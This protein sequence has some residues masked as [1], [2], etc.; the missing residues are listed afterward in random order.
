MKLF[1]KINSKR[2]ELDLNPSLPLKYILRLI[3]I[4]D[5]T[6]VKVVLRGKVLKC[7]FD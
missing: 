7:N 2:A 6:T 3:G 1:V 5:L 4:G